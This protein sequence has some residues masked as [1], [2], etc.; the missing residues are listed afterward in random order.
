[1]PSIAIIGASKDKSKFGNKAV[2]AYKSQGFEVFP[3]NLN[4]TE[5]EGLK[6][7]QSILKTPKKPDMA[8]LYLPPQVGIKVIEEVAKAGVKVI[9]I[10]PGA[11]S[12]KLIQKA[13]KLGLEPR[14]TCSIRAIGI[15]P[16]TL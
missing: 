13:K 10:N 2:R 9:Y 16:G 12:P 8:S 5:I 7:Y 15:D 4:E 11:E 14:M 1:M 3:I 6:T